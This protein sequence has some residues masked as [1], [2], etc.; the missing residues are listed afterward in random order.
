MASG[1][2][3]AEKLPFF[4]ASGLEADIVFGIRPVDANTGS[5]VLV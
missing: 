2:A 5:K 4:G 3:R 1:G